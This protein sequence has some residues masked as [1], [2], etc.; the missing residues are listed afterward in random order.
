MASGRG[1]HRLATVLL[2]SLRNGQAPRMEFDSKIFSLSLHRPF[3]S[4]ARGFD[5]G[6]KSHLSLQWVLDGKL[7]DCLGEKAV[8]HVLESLK[9]DHTYIFASSVK[10]SE[11]SVVEGKALADVVRALRKNASYL[12]TTCCTAV[13]EDK[14]EEETLNDWATLLG[15]AN[16]ICKNAAH[17][18]F[19]AFSRRQPSSIVSSFPVPN[20]VACQTGNSDTVLW[21]GN[22]SLMNNVFCGLEIVF[23]PRSNAEV[24]AF[25]HSLQARTSGHVAK[26]VAVLRCELPLGILTE[27]GHSFLLRQ[28]IPC[29]SASRSSSELTSSHS[30]CQCL[31]SEQY[32][33]AVE[34]HR[35]SKV[36]A[37]W[38]CSR[39][40][41]LIDINGTRWFCSWFRIEPCGSNVEDWICSAVPLPEK[42]TSN[43]VWL[44]IASFRRHEIG[45]VGRSD[46]YAPSDD[47]A[48][49]PQMQVVRTGEGRL[50]LTKSEPAENHVRLFNEAIQVLS[51]GRVSAPHPLSLQATAQGC[52]EIPPVSF[53]SDASKLERHILREWDAEFSGHTCTDSATQR[54]EK[55][56][57]EIPSRKRCRTL[58]DTT[59][60]SVHS[61]AARALLDRRSLFTSSRTSRMNSFPLKYNCKKAHGQRLVRAKSKVAVGGATQARPSVRSHRSVILD[62][63][64][65]FSNASTPRTWSTSDQRT[66]DF[67]ASDL[68]RKP[69]QSCSIRHRNSS[70]EDGILQS[71]GTVVSTDCS[72]GE[73]VVE[74]AALF[75]KS[76][77]GIFS[78]C[79]GGASSSFALASRN[80][81]RSDSSDWRSLGEAIA[82]VGD[83]IPNGIFGVEYCGSS[84]DGEDLDTALSRFERLH[85]QHGLDFRSAFQEFSQFACT[86]RLPE[87]L[88]AAFSSTANQP[89]DAVCERQ[90]MY[91]KDATYSKKCTRDVRL[92]PVEVADRLVTYLCEDGKCLDDSQRQWLEPVLRNAIGEFNLS[93]MA[94]LAR[95]PSSEELASTLL[96]DRVDG[97][98][99]D[100]LFYIVQDWIDSVRCGTISLNSVAV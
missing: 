39:T 56:S 16:I 37:S 91:E 9:P 86:G 58:S 47:I 65:E 46:V 41:F 88:C 42:H 70:P 83:S 40:A 75:R 90:D 34:L 60:D 55:Q 45:L 50:K 85:F 64:G 51:R 15:A 87:R 49:L 22:L 94:L 31:Q 61:E 77:Q 66:P 89:N 84:R 80:S 81:I 23:P 59:S 21:K 67:R 28:G 95:H 27:C 5:D 3:L 26:V 25:A 6:L 19:S 4:S 35:T 2:I 57:L 11:Y 72:K 100:G 62:G 82:A 14:P 13:F 7:I 53:A 10:L 32:C 73:G 78:Q 24:H 29:Y 33:S 97:K 43:S 79:I 38:R 93:S 54:S 12:R 8:S 74:S 76:R 1:I 69:G 98:H 30:A 63:K 71:K 44:D 18:L 96:R 20:N 99:K 68:R 48:R 17:I 92:S 36:L 52:R